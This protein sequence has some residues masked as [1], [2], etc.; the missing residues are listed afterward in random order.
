MRR[1]IELR[2]GSLDSGPLSPCG[3]FS[4]EATGEAVA[5]LTFLYDTSEKRKYRA[6]RR[7][8]TN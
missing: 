6:E 8:C 3:G 4:V 5:F 2:V 1:S 7:P